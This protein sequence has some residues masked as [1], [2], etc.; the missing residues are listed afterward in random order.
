MTDFVHLHVHTDYS[1]LDGAASVENLAR[2]AA[3]L[4][5]KSLAITD[6]GNMFGVLK[7]R[8]ACAGG[9]DHPIDHEPVK[10]IIGCEFYMA[11]NSRFEKSGSAD[12][13]D[14]YY[15]LVLLAMNTQGYKNLIMLD[16][17]AYT[18][19]F[20]YKPRIDNEL[21]LRYHE[22]LIGLSACIAGEIPR[23]LLRGDISAAEKRALWFRDLLGD[24]RFFLELQDHG[25]AAQRKLNPLIA[26][27]GKRL[28]IPLVATNDI[29]YVEK[30]DAE[31]QDILLC[32]SSKKT[33]NDPKRTFR[34]EGTEFYFKTGDE[35][36]ALFPEYPEAISNTVRI[37][38][39]C[40]AEIPSPG[41]LLPDF[42]IP[43]GFENA[44]EY[45]RHITFA[46]LEKRYPGRIEEIRER[47]EYELGVIIKM[48]FTG[49]FLIVQDFI[50]WAKEHDI[51]VG[52]GRG[53]GA[54][55]I[56][57]YALRITD[58]DP[59]KYNLLFERFLNPERISM[60]DF[61]VDFC[62]ERR[63]EVIQY[64]TKKYGSD[65][66]GQIITF[67]TLKARAVIKDVARALGIS[68]AESNQIV[69]LIPK[70]PKMTLKKAFAEEAKLIMEGT[71]KEAK[72]ADMEKRY[73]KLF[74]IARK[75]EGKNRNS[76]LHA[77]GVVIGKT[78][79]TDYVPLY[80]DPKTKGVASQ[81]TM[82]LIENQGLVKM[83]F[84]G[85]KTLD[86]IKNAV[87]LIRKRGGEYAQFNIETID[88]HDKATFK[89]LCEGR[90][91]G[92]FQFESEGMQ[93][94]L[95]DA[96]PGSITDLIALNALYRPGPMDY[97]P[98]YIECKQGRKPIEYPDPCL[99]SVL[100]ETYG[101]IVYQEQ[102]MQVAQRI[103]GYSLGQAD[104]LRKAMGKKKVE[105][106]V[107]EKARFIESAKA[108][109]FK[110]ED[111]DRI[112]EILIPFAGYGFNKSHASAYSVV[113]YQTAFLKAN[114]PAEFMAANLTNEI[115]GVDSLPACIEEARKM[116][117]V[118]DPPD[119]NRSEKYFT[120]VDGRIVYGFLGI[121]G[122]GEG[123]AEEIIRKRE[124]GPY[125]NMMDFLER[126]KIKGMGEDKWVIG[127]KMI[128]LLI[129]AGAFDCF[130]KNRAT[131]MI[132]LERAVDFAQIKK[133]EKK[134]GQESLFGY[135][136]V[137]TY[138]SFTFQDAPEWTYME[139]L[140]MEKELLGFYFSGHPMDEYKQ[141]WEQNNTLDLGHIEKAK[142]GIYT[143]VGIIKSLKSYQSSKGE[144]G[145]SSIADYNG[146]IDLVLFVDTWEK[147]RNK[148]ELEKVVAIR[149]KLDLSKKRERPSF[150]VDT[151]LDMENLKVL[152]QTRTAQRERSMQN[153]EYQELHI[154]LDEQASKTDEALY[155]LRELLQQCRIDGTNSA[156]S[157]NEVHGASKAHEAHGASSVN[158]AHEACVVFI[159]V[160]LAGGEQVVRTAV[161]IGSSD[162]TLEAIGRCAGVAQARYA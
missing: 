61:D 146:E 86:V 43:E 75:L 108:R 40:N 135:N 122:L 29:H 142:S 81:Y 4:G 49:Y 115:S 161:R 50:N 148:L 85:L 155:P 25:I 72:L 126:V 104:I 35:M 121:K 31:A 2:K 92:V 120:V 158:E 1:L 27:M 34:F 89:M 91:A 14:K 71:L 105:V 157:V 78:A 21:L 112:F 99:E 24:G 45:L 95:K 8:D 28:G 154:T 76:S 60:P 7:F 87:Q 38:E 9:K 20:Y 136:D 131:L 129:Q 69:E 150:I 101:V 137:E 159:H 106:M 102:V 117:V 143:L 139:K 33:V 32:I 77:A 127:K 15:H 156:S 88:E 113:A 100:Q 111:A 55:S 147:Y 10:P 82:E 23:L 141:V 118:I 74:E 125:K 51:P 94:I 62:N 54:S 153:K 22:G 138:Q 44:D 98:Q 116:G 36:A 140:N 65:R 134:F 39:L 16:S 52:P 162:A 47:A 132:N 123:P 79:L 66:V 107:K 130:G 119:I 73:P 26:D 46:G 110:R 19:G 83:D 149:G 37:A 18:E 64:V 59:L 53:S 133:D 17:Y 90:S 57:A 160:P 63:D 11:P 13:D 3:S 124:N 67:G 128:E 114:F 103:A 48:G 80:Y 84:L 151:L 109:G 6:H 5:M 58:I 93:K 68:L 41:P 42:A 96:Q 145:F 70:D 152:T 56:V 30:D 12:N 144:M 97:I